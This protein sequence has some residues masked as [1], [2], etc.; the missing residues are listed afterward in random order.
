MII[1]M[2]RLLLLLLLLPL[3]LLL[4]PLSR[5]GLHDRGQVLGAAGRERNKGGSSC[6]LLEANEKSWQISEYQNGQIK[7]SDLMRA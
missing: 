4:L 2:I 6:I 7:P 1:I 5:G 3:L